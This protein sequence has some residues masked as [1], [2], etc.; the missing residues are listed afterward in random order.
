MPKIFKNKIICPQ[1]FTPYK[2]EEKKRKNVVFLVQRRDK[3]NNLKTEA[4]I[5]T[6]RGPSVFDMLKTKL[7]RSI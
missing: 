3:I 4:T 5:K 6:E 1:C 7:K 2:I